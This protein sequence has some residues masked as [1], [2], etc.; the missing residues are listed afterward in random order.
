MY[1]CKINSTPC[2]LSENIAYLCKVV[3]T[4]DIYSWCVSLTPCIRNLVN[5]KMEAGPGS[6]TCHMYPY[7]NDMRYRCGVLFSFICF[8]VLPEPLIQISKPAPHFFCVNVTLRRSRTTRQR[9]SLLFRSLHPCAPMWRL[10]LD[11]P[12]NDRESVKFN[13][14]HS[15][16]KNKIPTFTKT[17]S[18]CWNNRIVAWKTSWE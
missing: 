1:F 4:T 10:W 6:N 8:R 3:Q 9:N 11:D 16:R 12:E 18:L 14:N 5:F 7:A 15:W 2:C 17:D 13:R